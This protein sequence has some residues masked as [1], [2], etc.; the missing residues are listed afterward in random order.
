MG[1]H[2]KNLR[3]R[4]GNEGTK[5]N[6]HFSP[7]AFT[8]V[9]FVVVIFSSTLVSSIFRTLPFAGGKPLLLYYTV[10]FLLACLLV[11]SFVSSN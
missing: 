5:K 11:R 4:C 3:K 8:R 6:L 2:K 9:L 1:E 7:N 10:F